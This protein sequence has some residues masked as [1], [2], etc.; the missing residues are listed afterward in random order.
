MTLRANLLFSSFNSYA[1][2]KQIPLVYYAFDLLNL[3]GTD[4]RPQP[5]IE[6]RKLLAKLLKKAPDNIRFSEELQGSREELSKARSQK[7]R[8]LFTNLAGVAAPG[9]K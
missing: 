6:R 8:I 1:I 7:G 5:L 9:L 4:L 3:E 2:R